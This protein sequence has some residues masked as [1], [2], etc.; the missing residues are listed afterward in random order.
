MNGSIHIFLRLFL[1][2]RS[3]L[4]FRRYSSTLCG[5]RQAT[6]GWSTERNR[7]RKT[8]NCSEMRTWRFAK[9]ALSVSRV[10][11]ITAVKKQ[12]TYGT[13]NHHAQNCERLTL[14]L[15]LSKEFSH[16]I[17]HAKRCAVVSRL[18]LLTVRIFKRLPACSRSCL[19]VGCH[20]QSL[21]TFPFAIR[22]KRNG[23]TSN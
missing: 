9:D 17:V 13:M 18:T 20:L 23:D 4:F 19:L 14:I 3:S 11:H 5:I 22:L 1:L 8:T 12:T 15:T 10:P 2:V 6:N 7:R 21:V 16:G